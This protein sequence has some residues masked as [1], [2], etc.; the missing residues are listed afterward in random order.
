MSQKFITMTEKESD[1]YDIIQDLINKKINGTDASK[2][3]GV[4]VRQVKR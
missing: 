3:I 2:M 1:R 4:S